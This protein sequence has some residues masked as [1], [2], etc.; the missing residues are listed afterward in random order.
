MSLA[1]KVEMGIA[2]LNSKITNKNFPM[3]VNWAITGRC[4]LR[5]THCYGT[6]GI[7][8]K[9]ELPIEIVKKT[10]DELK[11]MGTKRIT[12][13]G[14]EPL[15]REDIKE[16]IDYI[17]KKNIEMS[18]CT[19]GILIEK[20]I[21]FLKDKIDLIVLSLDGCKENHDAIRGKGNF[22]KV[23]SALKICKENNV[24]TLIFSCLINENLRDADCLIDIAK[25]NNAY[26][27]FNIAV[28]K[29]NQDGN[30]RGQ[31][32]KVSDDEYKKVLT[33]I[34]DNKR[35][36]AP[37]FYSDDNFIQAINWT[38]F[39]KE[40]YSADDLNL[41]DDK[42]KKTMIP[43]LAGKNYCYIECTGDVYP[44]YQ[45]VGIAAAK[46]VKETSAKDAFAYLS[47]SIFCKNCYN[48]ALTELNLQCA[49]NFK[50]VLKV[51]RNYGDNR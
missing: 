43:C 17:H 47:D 34:L 26:I 15:V 9:D 29:I 24:R 41:L 42:N 31:L 19:N 21:G 32:Q 40:H 3:I 45:M 33:K 2:L 16:I 51:I 36:G 49:L 4:N 30:S 5:C 10:I 23:I 20:Y 50:A 13:E 37:V 14:G 35:N 44:C 25:K 22:E 11:K 38:C 39:A 28:A 6:Y 27:A 48:F 46:N 1:K 18:L 8:Q 12:I 7:V